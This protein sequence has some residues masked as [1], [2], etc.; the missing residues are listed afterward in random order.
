MSDFTV[1]SED[2]TGCYTKL[3]EY[4]RSQDGSVVYSM[5]DLI[6]GLEGRTIVFRKLT[7]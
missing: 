2:G 3:D 7:F 5:P 6:V 1:G 4:V